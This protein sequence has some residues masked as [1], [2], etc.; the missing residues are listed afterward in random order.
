MN[1]V[2]ARLKSLFAKRGARCHMETR[3]IALE[4]HAPAVPRR[5]QCIHPYYNALTRGKTNII[6]II[7]RPI[8]TPERGPTSIRVE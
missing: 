2:Y 4:S 1:V 6:Y 8:T 7:T 5:I 3:G